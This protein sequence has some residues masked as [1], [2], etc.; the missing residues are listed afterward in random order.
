M[1]YRGETP[2][3]VRIVRDRRVCGGEPTVEGTRVP[4][5]AIVVQWRYYQDVDR[6]REAFPHLDAG[7]IKK[8]LRYYHKHRD[9][10]D[11]LV[12]EQEQAAYAID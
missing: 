4:V 11:R 7:T 12:E 10:I 6:V 3:V 8:A 5:S 1:A 9:E 2:S